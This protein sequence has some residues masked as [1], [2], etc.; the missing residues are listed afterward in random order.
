MRSITA[1]YSFGC[2]ALITARCSLK[3]STIGSMGF[4]VQAS[5]NS[6]IPHSGI[7]SVTTCAYICVPSPDNRSWTIYNIASRSRLPQLVSASSSC[8]I[9]F[10]IFII[11]TRS[12]HHIWSSLLINFWIS[13]RDFSSGACS[14]SSSSFSE[15]SSTVSV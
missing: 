13:I 11:S 14:I 3:I 1:R 7:T 5:S 9:S 15:I 10:P 2:K 12:P 6:P 4:P 8:S